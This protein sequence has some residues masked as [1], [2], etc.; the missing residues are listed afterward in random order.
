M[1]IKD[2]IGEFSEEKRKQVESTIDA[3]MESIC[4]ESVKW[5]E[6]TVYEESKKKMQKILYNLSI[7]FLLPIAEEA[8]DSEDREV[9]IFCSPKSKKEDEVECV[10]ANSTQI[11]AT[12]ILSRKTLK[13]LSKKEKS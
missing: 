2:I 13:Y 12:I 9:I 3:C 11:H 6:F 1:K 5:K 8:R 7:G 4:C 10:K